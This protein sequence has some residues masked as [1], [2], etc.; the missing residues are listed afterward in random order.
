MFQLCHHRARTIFIRLDYD[1]GHF[2]L[3]QHAELDFYCATYLYIQ[4]LLS[5]LTSPVILKVLLPHPIWNLQML[6]HYTMPEQKK[7]RKYLPLVVFMVFNIT[8]NNISVMHLYIEKNK[9]VILTMCFKYISNIL[10][11]FTISFNHYS[12]YL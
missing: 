11:L 5:I 10:C 9:F 7:N 12:W 3:E 1:N 6:N 8:F 4:Q 2:V